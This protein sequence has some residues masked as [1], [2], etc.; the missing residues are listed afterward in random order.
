MSL[1]DLNFWFKTAVS[2][3]LTEKEESRWK[4][5]V[6]LKY[7]PEPYREILVSFCLTLEDRGQKWGCENVKAMDELKF[8]RGG[9]ID[10]VCMLADIMI[11]DARASIRKKVRSS[12]AGFSPPAVTAPGGPLPSASAV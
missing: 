10:M 3:N 7:G 8:W 12:A 9:P 2:H 6:E 1:D 5:W 11:D 4:A